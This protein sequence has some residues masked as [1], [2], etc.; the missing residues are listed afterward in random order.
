VYEITRSL[1]NAST[2]PAFAFSVSVMMYPP[3]LIHPYKRIAS[4]ITQRFSDN[5]RVRHRRTGWM[6]A[7][8][9]YKYIGKM[10]ALHFG[11]YVKYPLIL[12]VYSHR[13]HLTYQTRE[14]CSKL[15]II[16]IFLY[17]NATRLIQPL[18]VAT[19]SPLKLGLKT[20]VLVWY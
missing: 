10:F 19:F 15:G 9:V 1:A 4:V 17:P 6:A 16:W 12:Y 13:T 14:L 18:D 20:A 11:K 5:W 3:M 8:V 7:D 2:T